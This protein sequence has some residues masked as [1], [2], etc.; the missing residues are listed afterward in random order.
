MVTLCISSVVSFSKDEIPITK[1]EVEKN[2]RES[3][4]SLN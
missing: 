3:G 4:K 1:E 2:D